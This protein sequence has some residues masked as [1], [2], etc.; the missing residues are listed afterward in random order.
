MKNADNESRPKRRSERDLRKFMSRVS[1]SHPK[2]R[3]KPDLANER[4]KSQRRGHN[5]VRKLLP[6]MRFQ[7]RSGSRKKR[8]RSKQSQ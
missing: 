1:Q 8:G 3:R 6:L 2:K 5:K 7:T 4:N